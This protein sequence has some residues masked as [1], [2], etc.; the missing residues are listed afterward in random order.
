MDWTGKKLYGFSHSCCFAGSQDLGNLNVD[1]IQ[2]DFSPSSLEEFRGISGDETED[3][4]KT[5]QT[6]TDHILQLNPLS[7]FDTFDSLTAHKVDPETNYGFLSSPSSS[8][9]ASL[10][11]SPTTPI[12]P[13]PSLEMPLETD[14]F[15]TDCYTYFGNNQSHAVPMGAY[16]NSPRHNHVKMAGRYNKEEKRSFEKWTQHVHLRPDGSC[17]CLEKKNAKKC[18]LKK[19]E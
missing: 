17:K 3:F 15:P 18:V 1:D 16:P 12:A 13:L 10:P 14:T 9:S 7:Y 6:S 8:S 4:L 19:C 11:P 5:V 2:S